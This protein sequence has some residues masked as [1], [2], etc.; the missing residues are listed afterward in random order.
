M[1]V[2]VLMHWGGSYNMFYISHVFQQ[3]EDLHILNLA[4]L[5]VPRPVLSE[6]MTH[7]HIM[8]MMVN[9]GSLQAEL[10]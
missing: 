4:S 7:P 2:H 8:L 5:Y 1:E 9:E 6:G 10:I 3:K